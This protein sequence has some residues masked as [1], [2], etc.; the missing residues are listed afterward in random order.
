MKDLN[1]AAKPKLVPSLDPNFRPAVLWNRAYKKTVE[2]S[3]EAVPLA[4]ALE[5]DGGQIAVYETA[6][7]PPG[8]NSDWDQANHFYVERLVKCLLWTKG[9]WKITLAGPGEVGRALQQ[10]Y[11]Q[12]GSRAFDA[13]FMGRVYEQAFTVEVTDYANA[14]QRYEKTEAVGGHLEGCRIGFDAGGSDRK[15]AAV[16][17]GEVLFS[18]ETVWLPK[19]TEDPDYHFAGILD[20]VQ[21]AAQHLPRVDAI[22][23]SSAGI[24]INNRTMVASLFLKVPEKLFNEKV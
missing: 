17:D 16:M 9:G 4:I 1:T 18:D 14:P 3:G 21:R 11:R 2:A 19:V 15:V 20:S 24:Y 22:G 7:F 10:A 8:K 23:V 12:G 5:R 13:E 6:V